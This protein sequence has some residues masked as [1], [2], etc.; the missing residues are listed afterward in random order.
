MKL[1]DADF[2]PHG[3]TVNIGEPGVKKEFNV[4]AAT[5]RHRGFDGYSSWQVFIK[6]VWSKKQSLLSNKSVYK[7]LFRSQQSILRN[8]SHMQ[9]HKRLKSCPIS[10]HYNSLLTTS[11]ASSMK[12]SG[13]KAVTYA[14]FDNR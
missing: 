10:S 12:F 11:T 5:M 2:N 6:I 8:H 7:C 3:C 4:T 13:L 9:C 14:D 1:A